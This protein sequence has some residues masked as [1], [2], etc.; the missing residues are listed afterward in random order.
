M[1]KENSLPEHVA[2]NREYWDANADWWVNAGERSWKQGDPSWGI[3]TLPESQLQLLPSDLSKMKT[4]E[5]GCGTTY[6]SCWMMRRGADAVGIDNSAQQLKTA[7]RLMNEYNMPIELIHGNAE[8]VPYADES[9]DFAIS[10]YGAAIWCDPYKWI[11]EAWRLLRPGGQLVFLGT[12]PLAIIT[13]PADGSDSGRQLHRSYFDLHKQDWS[14]L[15]SDPGG[16]EFNLPHS[17]WQRLF[18]NTGFEILDYQELQAPQNRIDT[19]FAIPG[20]WAQQWPSEQ[21]WKLRKVK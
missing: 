15:E 10:E 2:V 12:H 3:W 11:P 1:N 17:A 6:V 8:A 16:I 19:Q 4:I 21:V 20:S 13:T 5:L 7:H 14:E 9:F 18:R